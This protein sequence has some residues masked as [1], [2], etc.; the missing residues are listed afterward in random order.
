MTQEELASR[1]GLGVRTISNLERGVNKTPYQNTVRRLADALELPDDERASLS[2]S[3]RPLAPHFPSP[4][5][6]PPLPI[7][8]S[9]SFRRF[10]RG[11]SAGAARGA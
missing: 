3:A 5:S 9:P 7:P 2:A 8:R 11:G 1:S 4:T 10:S 6:H